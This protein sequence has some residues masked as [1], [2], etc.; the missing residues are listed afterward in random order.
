VA[1]NRD[2]VRKSPNKARARSSLGQALIYSSPE[3]EEEGVRELKYAIALDPNYGFSY[4]TLG[5]Y[6]LER[7]LL[8]EAINNLETAARLMPDF[9]KLYYPLSQAYFENQQYPEAV[10]A[11]RIAITV[12][13]YREK[14][15]LTLG[16]AGS[17]I[18]DFGTAISSFSE[19]AQNHPDNGRYR[20]NLGRALEKTGR[21]ELALQHYAE[22]LEI[23]PEA[24]KKVIQQAIDELRNRPRGV[25]K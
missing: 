12:P 20:Y 21:P 23:S 17:E 24:D 13:A 5:G 11:A 4:L 22:A 1:L 14:V 8:T 7:G 16:I 6:Y 25:T 19:L 3:Q 9:T 10:A 15:L 18:G 2:I